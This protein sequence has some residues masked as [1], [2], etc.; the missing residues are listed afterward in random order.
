LYCADPEVVSRCPAGGGNL[1]HCAVLSTR[2]FALRY[3]QYIDGFIAYDGAA[4]TSRELAHRDRTLDQFYWSASIQ[5]DR[6]QLQALFTLE[7]ARKEHAVL[8]G[9]VGVGKTML[10]QCLV[11]LPCAPATASHSCALM[12]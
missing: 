7:L 2:D 1:A 10:A 11:P 8:V 12:R 4:S 9:P 3:V 5:V 6:R